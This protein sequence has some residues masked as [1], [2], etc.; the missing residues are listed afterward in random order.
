MLVELPENEKVETNP[1]KFMLKHELRNTCP[2]VHLVCPDVKSSTTGWQANNKVSSNCAGTDLEW[3]LILEIGL[4]EVLNEVCDRISVH[5]KD[6][7]FNLR[8][9][10][11][12]PAG[13]ESFCQISA[14]I[15]F[16][17]VDY[18][19]KLWL[20]E[21]LYLKKHKNNLTIETWKMCSFV[22]FNVKPKIMFFGRQ[23][24]T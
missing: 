22:T 3:K 23:A 8:R 16:H 19:L 18:H 24:S 14:Q 17:P 10:D 12:W 7:K 13:V 21:V 1:V 4:L 6:Q 9:K 15:I 2:S 11:G 20:P 5:V